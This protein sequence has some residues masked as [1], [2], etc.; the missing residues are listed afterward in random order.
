MLANKTYKS[1]ESFVNNKCKVCKPVGVSENETIKC[2]HL[3][4]LFNSSLICYLLTTVSVCL[5]D[6]VF[7]CVSVCLPHTR[8]SES[9]DSLTRLRDGIAISGRD[10]NVHYYY[11]YYS[12]LT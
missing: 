5:Y 10:I 12:V 4:N 11:Y 8:V 1:K 2:I 9:Q 7:I 3:N 6:Y